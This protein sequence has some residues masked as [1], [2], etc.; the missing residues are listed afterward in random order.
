M[1][2]GQY[3]KAVSLYQKALAKGGLPD[4]GATKLHLGVAYAGA[5]QTAQARDTFSS[6]SG[7]G[8]NGELAGLWLIAL[9]S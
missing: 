3:E 7:K 4:P 8:R 1:S 6:L 9:G 5:K 2:N